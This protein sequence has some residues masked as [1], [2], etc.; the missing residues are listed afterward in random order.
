MLFNRKYNTGRFF[1]FCLFSLFINSAGAQGWERPYGGIANETGYDIITCP[2]GGYAIAGYHQESTGSAKDMLLLRLDAD[3]DTLWS[4]LIG[5]TG[6]DDEAMALAILPGGRWAVCGYTKSNGAVGKDAYLAFLDPTGRIEGQYQFGDSEYDQFNDLVFDETA[7]RLVLAGYTM[8]PT[9]GYAAYVVAVDLNGVL[10]WESSFGGAAHEISNAIAIS[11]DGGYLLA[12]VEF[13][14]TAEQDIYIFKTDSAGELVWEQYFPLSGKE[15]AKDLLALPAGELLIL[16]SKEVAENN[17]DYYLIKAGADGAFQW[18][19]TFGSIGNDIGEA[20]AFSPNGG[21]LLAG[22][23]GSVPAGNESISLIEVDASGN[24]QWWQQYGGDQ[25]ESAFGIVSTTDGYVVTGMTTSFGNGNKD[26]YVVKTD[27]QGNLLTN[28]IK[29]H[30]FADANGNC[31]FD[32][33]EPPQKGWMI[34]ADG[35]QVYHGWTD[36]NG[37]FDLVLPAGDY[38]VSLIPPNHYWAPCTPSNTVLLNTPYQSAT[39]YLGTGIQITC[40]DI[41]TDI[42]TPWLSPC[43]QASYTIRYE[44]KGTVTATNSFL[45]VFLDDDLTYNSATLPAQLSINTLTI[46]LGDLLPG[47]S[48]SVVVKAYLN[49]NA[50]A[51]ETHPVTVKAFPNTICTPPASGWNGAAISTGITA[52]DDS[53]H[54]EIKN[55][56]PAPTEAPVD[57]IVI[58]DELIY[59]TGSAPLNPGQ[60]FAVNVP[61][62]GATWR[63]QATQVAGF[64]GRSAPCAAIEGYTWQTGQPPS[65]GHI[66]KFPADDGNTFVAVD[67]QENTDAFGWHDLRGYPTGYGEPHYIEPATDIDYLIRFH[68]TTGDTL[69]F[70]E[71]KDTIPANLDIKSIVPGASSHP[72]RFVINGDGVIKFFIDNAE[73]PNLETNPDDGHG[74]IRF[75]IS[76]LPDLPTGTTIHNRAMIS[77]NGE[78]FVHTNTTI[79]TIKPLGVLINGLIQTEDELPVGNVTVNAGIPPAQLVQWTDEN[80][81]FSFPMLAADAD[82]KIVPYRNDFFING[83]TTYDILLISKHILGIEP[84]GSP[85]KMIAADV[86][87]SGTITAAD[88]LAIR[89]LI[90]GMTDSF[91]GN[92]SWR[93]VP[94]SYEF[95]DSDNPFNADIPTDYDVD[96]LVDNLQVDFTGIKTGDVNNSVEPEFTDP[97]SGIEDRDMKC[98]LRVV[99][100]S[101]E[102]GNLRYACYFDLDLIDSR[103]LLEG[104][105]ATI[106]YDKDQLNWSHI[107]AATAKITMD[108]LGLKHVNEGI[109][110]VSWETLLPLTPDNGSPLFYFS[111]QPLKGVKTPPPLQL[112][113]ALT[114]S[115]AYIR[116]EGISQVADIQLVQEGVGPDNLYDLEVYPN[117]TTGKVTV[118]WS[119]EKP[120][121]GALTMT[122]ILGYSL[123]PLTE[124]KWM[125][126]G[127][128]QLHIR[129]ED[130]PVGISYIELQTSDKRQMIKL[131]RLQ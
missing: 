121:V 100:E 58:E 81:V 16:G 53:I 38:V 93:F 35:A 60:S 84:L 14:G 64:P 46:A 34:R 111:F 96:N 55:E 10:L 76:Q 57:Y 126:P 1:I 44:N 87:R 6:V 11:P 112:G 13:E 51:G 67:Y 5:E 127:R 123:V 2:D 41:F 68:N 61:A 86:N 103:A 77:Y 40:P 37:D 108:N 33:G 78:A 109:I 74:F 95:Q 70:I 47:Q 113:S 117:P 65:L 22:T 19:K 63:I 97:P 120:G 106:Y 122:D 105:Q 45:K 21:F 107:E 42:A 89:Q 83:V 116:L 43:E 48:G 28:H 98:L 110:T 52:L 104:F 94:A 88:M 20:I 124:S 3:G 115:E 9:L 32:N 114:K 56:G 62:N 125:L 24:E 119:I 31:T 18:S 99:P 75:R 72:Y 69:H 26:L 4:T 128:Y 12:G 29:G 130:I 92:T 79:H 50:L 23:Y 71:I 73:M 129:Q 27:A 102:R 36:V 85:F 7:G 101:M 118:N 49:C 80:G 25:S 15:Q 66:D 39:L 90:L 82:Y 8:T 17:T 59:F 54:F 131:V 30:V 91:P